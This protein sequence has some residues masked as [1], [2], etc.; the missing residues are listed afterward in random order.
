MAWDDRPEDDVWFSFDRKGRREDPEPTRTRGGPSFLSVLLGLVAVAIAVVVW[1]NQTSQDRAELGPRPTGSGV[2]TP[3]PTGSPP[4]TA[5]A[6]VTTLPEMRPPLGSTTPWDLFALVGTELLRIEMATGRTTVVEA[7]QDGTTAMVL[8][9]L[10]DGVI[11]QPRDEGSGYVVLD[12]G[13]DRIS[14]SGLTGPGRLVR[15]LGTDRLWFVRN[16]PGNNRLELVTEQ[17]TVVG[18]ASTSLAPDL[19]AVSARSDGGLA[20]I[21]EGADGTYRVDGSSIRRIT[22][23]KVLG[24]AEAGWLVN[25]CDDLHRCGLEFVDRRTSARRSLGTALDGDDQAGSVSPDGRHA[26][27]AETTEGGTRSLLID[28]V[29]G[30]RDVLPGIDGFGEGDPSANVA[31]A[32]DSQWAVVV[33]AAGTLVGVDARSGSLISLR[34]GR[35]Y[36]RAALA[37]R[38]P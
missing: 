33:T 2:V 21:V 17:G 12:D 14:T 38:Y 22:T 30:R 9:P 13:A 6:T 16:V 8:V 26:F 5:S 4:V 19:F 3:P 32:P 11:I 37:A 10:T 1:V 29:T 25:E 23:G 36:G 15:A 27:V 24:R 31:W 34:V 7:P 28:L 18:D 20:V 35:E